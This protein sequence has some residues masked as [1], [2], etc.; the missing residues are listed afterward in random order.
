M[1][2]YKLKPLLQMKKYDVREDTPTGLVDYF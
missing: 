1:L 2:K